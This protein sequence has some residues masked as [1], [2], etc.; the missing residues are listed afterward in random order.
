MNIEVYVIT[1]NEAET[2]RLFIKHYQRLG[3]TIKVFD[4]FSDDGT[5]YICESLGCQVETFGIKGELNDAQYRK[6]KNY[7][8]K[9][10]KADWVI[11]CDADEI[12]DIS[13]E[14]LEQEKT[15]TIFR[16]HGFN[17]YSHDMPKDDYFEILTGVPDESYSKLVIFNPNRISDMMYEYGC[18]QAN[19][20]GTVVYSKVDP[21]LFHYR[22]I[23]GPERM[24]KRHAL[25]RSRMGELNK[26]MGLGIHYTYSDERRIQEWHEFYV[27]SVT[28]SRAGG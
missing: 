15:A 9:G 8:W 1:F 27:K 26:R 13:S 11:V 20:Y 10:S 21:T 3:A 19:P 5:P 14:T 4:N 23:G 22:A 18:H 7:K 6:I 12:L 16:T 25:Y 2:I 17:I 24:V 28:Y